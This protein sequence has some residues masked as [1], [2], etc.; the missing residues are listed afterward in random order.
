MTTKKSPWSDKDL[1]SDDQSAEPDPTEPKDQ[2]ATHI[3]EQTNSP[4]NPR[5][6]TPKEPY[7]DRS[8]H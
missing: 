2:N 7:S 4:G 1:V 3:H 8:K 5:K 6:K